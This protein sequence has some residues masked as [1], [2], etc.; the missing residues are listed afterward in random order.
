[1]IHGSNSVNILSLGSTEV[2][3][4]GGDGVTYKLPEIA[5]SIVLQD[6]I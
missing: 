4:I 5:N 2:I 1:M 6:N 3:T